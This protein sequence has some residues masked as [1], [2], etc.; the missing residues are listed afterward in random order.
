MPRPRCQY[1]NKKFKPTGLSNHERFCKK[2]RSAPP[3][4]GEAVNTVAVHPRVRIKE[5]AEA[6]WNMLSFSEKLMAI[7]LFEER[8]NPF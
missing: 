7:S 1:C 2:T 3:I 4:Q 5:A 8:N 6:F